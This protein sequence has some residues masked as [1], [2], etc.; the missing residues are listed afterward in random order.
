MKKTI[1]AGYYQQILH[2]KEVDYEMIK[3]EKQVS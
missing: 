3:V 2:D 1:Q